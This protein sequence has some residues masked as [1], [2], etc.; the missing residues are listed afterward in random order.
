MVRICVAL[1][2]SDREVSL[3]P[4]SHE[5]EFSDWSTNVSVPLQN[6]TA[7][8]FLLNLI[9]FNFFLHHLKAFCILLKLEVQNW[10]FQCGFH[11]I[12][13]AELN[14]CLT[15]NLLICTKFI[16]APFSYSIIWELLLS[17]QIKHKICPRWL[18]RI[19]TAM[20]KG[21]TGF[22]NFSYIVMLQSC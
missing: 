3:T 1:F 15:Q 11:K 16:L 13:C 4:P 14:N 7:S 2:S 12:L 10:T 5:C 17:C 6:L 8:N 19:E 9:N 21:L 22:L 20:R 18:L